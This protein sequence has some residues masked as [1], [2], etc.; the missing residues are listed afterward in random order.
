MAP[1]PAPLPSAR[2]RWPATRP[3]REPGAA[4]SSTPP[5][6]WVTA[7]TRTGEVGADRQPAR[8]PG[9]YWIARVTPGGLGVVPIMMVIGMAQPE[10]APGGM[11]QLTWSIPAIRE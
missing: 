11:T 1:A 10:G 9:H 7:E 6:R 3:L 2:R 4:R 8:N 5:I